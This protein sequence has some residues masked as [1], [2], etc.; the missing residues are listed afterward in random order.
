MRHPHRWRNIGLGF[1]LSGIVATPLPF[2]IRDGAVSDPVLG[3]LFVYGLMAF[4]FG[5][6]IALMRHTEARAWESLRRGEEIIACW[7]VDGATWRAFLALND[8]VNDGNPRKNELTLHLR[9]TPPAGGVDVIVSRTGV[10]IDGD[11]HHLP[12]HGVPHV[13]HA[14]LVPGNPSYIDLSL[15]YP[16]GGRGASGIPQRWVRTALRFPIGQGQE[17][18]GERA[19][20]HYNQDL[21]GKPDFFHGHGDGTDPEDLSKCYACGYATHK[22]IR[23]CPRCGANMQSRRWSRRFGWGLAVC[24]LIITGLMVPVLYYTVPLLLQPGVDTG[25]M[26]F[27]GSAQQARLV[28]GLLGAVFV[29]GASALAYGIWQIRTGQRS[30]KVICFIV[31]LAAAM[32]FIATLL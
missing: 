28:L 6:M 2:L 26:R 9:K 10:E 7:H 29:F 32:Y 8:R 23:A 4:F 17:R 11:F 25:G 24:G 30:K 22:F 21:P 15:F 12:P 18:E 16:A 27:S 13:E 1:C 3:S 20:A 5:G 14:A 31:G 19:F